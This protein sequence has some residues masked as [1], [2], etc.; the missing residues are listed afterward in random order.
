MTHHWFGNQ[1]KRRQ[2]AAIKRHTVANILSLFVEQQRCSMARACEPRG[3]QQRAPQQ[4]AQVGCI[5]DLLGKAMQS[6]D[7]VVFRGRSTLS[8]RGHSHAIPARL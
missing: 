7:R 1:L 3:G 4:R 6:L 2:I 8:Q 5:S